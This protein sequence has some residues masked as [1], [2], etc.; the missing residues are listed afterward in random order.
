MTGE[1]AEGRAAARERF[2]PVH[3]AE[4]LDALIEHGALA[5]EVERCRSGTS[6]D[7]SL[8]SFTHCGGANPTQGGLEHRIE[9]WLRHAFGEDI[10]FK[11]A[12]ALAKLVRLDL[13]DRAG[14]R[15]TAPVPQDAL[16]RLRR[17]WTGLFPTELPE[18][19]VAARA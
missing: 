5:S 17:T 9:G 4:P 11:V 1:G 19:A 6:A 15:L 3:K 10:T 2:I 18:T 16:A 7:L 8:T 12:D 13:L 14:G